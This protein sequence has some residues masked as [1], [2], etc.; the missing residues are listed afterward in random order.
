MLTWINQ[1]RIEKAKQII[2]AD[3][4]ITLADIAQQIGY[5]SSQTFIRIF[6]RYEG[7]TPGQYRAQLHDG[8]ADG[9][10]SSS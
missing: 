4:S 1:R 10:A 3:E 2:A 5:N 9:E 8:R 7:V 6:K